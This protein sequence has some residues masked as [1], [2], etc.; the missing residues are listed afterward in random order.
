MTAPDDGLD[1]K[2]E[3]RDDRREAD[4]YRH[5]FHQEKSLS[6]IA[7]LASALASIA[8]TPLDIALLEPE[9]LRFF[10]FIRV[11]VF[12]TAAIA[13]FLIRKSATI[14]AVFR[15][16]TFFIMSFFTAN[17]LVFDHPSLERHGGALLPLVGVGLSVFAR[18]RTLPVFVMTVYSVGISLL[19][20]GV[21]RPDPETVPDLAIIVLVTTVGMAVGAAGRIQFNRMQREA[22]LHLERERENN[23]ALNQARLAAEAGERTKSEFMAVMSH[24]IRTPMHGILG[25]LQLTSSE[26]L[27]RPQRDRIALAQ[28]SARAL[29]S[30]L[31][32]ILDVSALEQGSNVFEARAFHLPGLLQ[33]IVG[34]MKPTF[35]AKALDFVVDVA[36]D[37]P[38]FVVGDEKRLRQVL[39][40][41]L[42]NAAKFT[43]HGSVTLVVRPARVEGQGS[44]V[45]FAVVDTGIGMSAEAMRHLF[46]PFRQADSSIRRR[47]GGTGLGLLICRHLVEGM[48]GAIGVE[49]EEGRGSRFHVRLPLATTDEA[50]DRAPRPAPIARADRRW[51]LLV[52]EDNR[53]NQIVTHGLLE[54]A[55]HVV[56]IAESGA[57]A[58]ELATEQRF[59]AILMD[60]Q[61]PDM[62]GLETCRRIRA[63]PS[64]HAPTPIVALSANSRR[65][66]MDAAEAAGMNGFL[67][68]PIDMARL[69]DVLAGTVAEDGAFSQRQP[70]LEIGDDVLIVGE[71]RSSLRVL[72]QGLGLRVFAAA[73]FD[74][75]KAMIAA[76]PFPAILASAPPPGFFDEIRRIRPS[77]SRPVVAVA[78]MTEGQD[79]AVGLV[80]GAHYAFA[81]SYTNEEMERVFLSL[82]EAGASS[83]GEAPEAAL[84]E[85]NLARLRLVFAAGLREA[86]AGLSRPDVAPES[87]AAIAHRLKGS[88]SSLQMGDLAATADAAIR[89]AEALGH[90]REN[91]ERS[92][93][94]LLA[95]IS[96]RLE[97]IES[98]P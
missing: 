72:L 59:D 10:L 75:A 94:E 49:S 47:Y 76:R 5:V 62:D 27:T 87:V 64:D 44:G 38:P 58:I 91:H 71:T 26:P 43:E 70:V 51:F 7:I 11:V 74:A 17:A 1:F 33:E 90:E 28:E 32:D 15:A 22:Y 77:R 36:A 34:L 85:E 29:L 92:R 46:Q 42:S 16:N 52:V 78:V 55:G 37:V 35:S 50:D 45:A 18:G 30:I 93:S 21:F 73:S 24:E 80:E 20:W 54:K 13:L 82:M 88:A 63:L 60:L 48:G 66:D 61:M 57:R 19:Y 69:A 12:C 86:H 81:A 6:A 9:R 40:N 95:A 56:M 3:F 4:Y 84:G 97:T 83:A 14:T 89:A 79:A 65:S 67:S 31:D 41:L 23:Q 2:G 96:A 39:L 8:F 98:L 53:V 68:K 25:L